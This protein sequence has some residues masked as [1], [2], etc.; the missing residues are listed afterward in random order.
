MGLSDYVYQRTRSRLAGLTD[1]EY[2][3]E[4]VALL[5]HDPPDGLRGLSR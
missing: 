3:W 2:F 5:L 4:P 1:D